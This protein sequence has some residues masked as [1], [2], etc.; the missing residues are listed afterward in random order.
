MSLGQ[1][2]FCDHVSKNSF[3]ANQHLLYHLNTKTNL[4]K[5]LLF[6]NQIRQILNMQANNPL[7]YQT[8]LGIPTFPPTVA[9][10]LLPPVIQ[11]QQQ[12]QQQQSSKSSKS[13]SKFNGGRATNE[14]EYV[15]IS[16]YEKFFA[17]LQ[18]AAGW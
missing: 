16:E 10:T 4:P 7:S 14:P 5:N 9:Q 8:L 13:Q 6:E 18:E 2:P 11:Q 17:V 3:L 1:C 12:Q 15:D